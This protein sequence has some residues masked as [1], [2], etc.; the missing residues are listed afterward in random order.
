MRKFEHA[1]VKIR[2]L[3]QVPVRMR[4]RAT[5]GIWPQKLHS[6]VDN[7]PENSDMNLVLCY[8]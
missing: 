3:N 2:T 1:H 4:D 7:I 5:Q 6:D 8:K